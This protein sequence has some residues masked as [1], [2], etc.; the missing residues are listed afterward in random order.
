MFA[1]KQIS[2]RVEVLGIHTNVHCTY[3][4][5]DC[6]SEVNHYM[7]GVGCTKYL[8]YVRTIYQRERILCI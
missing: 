6:V 5:T 2:V 7:L 8:T 4:S 1:I 3:V